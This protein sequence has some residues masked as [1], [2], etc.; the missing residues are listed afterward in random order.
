MPESYVV[1]TG[2]RRPRSHH[3]STVRSGDERHRQQPPAARVLRVRQ[4]RSG[5]TGDHAASGASTARSGAVAHGLACGHYA[6]ML[7]LSR[8]VLVVKTSM[9]LTGT[10]DPVPAAAGRAGD[11]T[12]SGAFMAVMNDTEELGLDIPALRTG[13]DCS[14]SPRCCRRSRYAPLI[15]ARFSRDAVPEITRARRS[16][17]RHVVSPATAAFPPS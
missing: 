9:E 14:A 13:H 10:C 7:A 1:T 3:C 16:E 5:Q 4:A 8:G 2:S 15:S 6:T 11:P 12:A 17:L